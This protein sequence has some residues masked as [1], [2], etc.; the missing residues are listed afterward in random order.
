MVVLIV[1]VAE[2]MVVVLV[3]VDVVDV[4]GVVVVAVVAAQLVTARRGFDIVVVGVVAPYSGRR[5]IVFVPSYEGLARTA[6]PEWSTAL[7]GRARLVCRWLFPAHLLLQSASSLR[8]N[9]GIVGGC[10]IF[11]TLAYLSQSLWRP[12]S[13]D[14]QASPWSGRL[15]FVSETAF[16]VP[17]SPVCHPAYAGCVPPI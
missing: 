4:A 8:R 11:S 1:V 6:A 10:R 15:V 17:A 7:S 12:R 3:V 9:S 2:L 14:V 13:L 16:A 5:G